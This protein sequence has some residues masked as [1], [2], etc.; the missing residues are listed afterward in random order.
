M[1]KI[2]NKYFEMNNFIKGPPTTIEKVEKFDKRSTS[3]GA[4]ACFRK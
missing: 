4:L 3:S 2:P 1:E